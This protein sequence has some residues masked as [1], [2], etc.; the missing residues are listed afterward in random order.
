MDPI[1]STLQNPFG[2]SLA[3]RFGVPVPETLRRYEPGQPLLVGPAALGGAPG[4]RLLAGVRTVVQGAG[5]DL[6]AG[7]GDPEM[8]PASGLRLGALIYDASG[9]ARVEDLVGLRD[10]F[11]PRLRALAPCARVVVLGTPPEAAGSL[12]AGVVQR[13][14]EGF[15]RSLAKELP[16]GATA[17]L[18]LVDHG[19]EHRMESTLRFLL[20]AR[21]AFVDGQVVR[22]GTSVSD[23]EPV[24]D[25]Q[26]PLAGRVVVVT[27]ASRGIGA[28]MVRTFARDGAMVLGVDVPALAAELQQITAEV[29]GAALVTDVTAADTAGRI[30]GLVRAEFGTLHAIVHNA[31]ITRDRRLVNLSSEAWQQVIAVNLQAPR[32][33]SAELVEDGVLERGGRIVGISSIAGIAGN[34]GQTNYATSKAGILG[35]VTLL[36]PAVAARGITVNALAPG[37][38]ETQMTQKV[39]LMIR[40][41]GRRLS[42]LGQGGLPVDVAETA[43]WLLSPASSGITGQVIRV[44]GQGLIGA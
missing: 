2:R 7:Q 34:L 18:V 35:L 27:G 28:A 40:E 38:I 31:G 41:G 13:S 11:A 5:A 4:G 9:L 19:A 20:S 6:V 32:R 44:C 23:L 8:S 42:S 1:Q 25:W 29:N 16:R 17:Q 22:I 26:R 14:L 3:R 39:P 36:A 24:N 21:S 33:I 37:F 12:D 30:A 10:F 15:S 43:A